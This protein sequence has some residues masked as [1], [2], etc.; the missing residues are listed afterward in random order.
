MNIG[1]MWFDNDPAKA[2]SL[3][4]DQAAAFYQKKYGSKPDVCMVNPVNL[5]AN[6]DASG[7]E[8]GG[9]S[10]R[11]LP[12]QSILPGHLWIGRDD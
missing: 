7:I 2:L 1:M 12:L 5:P 9:A 6:P 3:K 8:N 11:L 4:V 10:I